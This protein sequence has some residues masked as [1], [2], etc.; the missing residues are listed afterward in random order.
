MS[1]EIFQNYSP[2]LIGC[3]NELERK[4]DKK[5]FLQKATK[6]EPGSSGTFK[7]LTQASS[8]PRSG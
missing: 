1:S 2:A 3:V 7:S 8:Q 6:N 5:N 4:N